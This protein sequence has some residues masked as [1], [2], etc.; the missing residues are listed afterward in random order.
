VTIPVVLIPGTG[1]Q[2]RSWHLVEAGLRHLAA[3]SRPEEL[4]AALA[5]YLSG[6]RVAP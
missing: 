4:S 2:G 3:L 5:R 1:G 6:P